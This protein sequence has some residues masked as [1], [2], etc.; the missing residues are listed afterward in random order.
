MQEQFT[1]SIEQFGVLFPEMT[2]LYEEFPDRFMAGM[3]VAHAPS[4]KI[5]EGRVQR[6]RVL[7]EQLSPE[8]RTKIVE[9]NAIL[10]FKLTR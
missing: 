4:W 8:T 10:I 9:Q 6:T 3:D 5:H 2:F 1:S 7:L